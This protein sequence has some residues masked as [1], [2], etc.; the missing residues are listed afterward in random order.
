MSTTS[1]ATIV[2]ATVPARGG[3]FTFSRAAATKAEGG[4]FVVELSDD[5]GHILHI[6]FHGADLK[7]LVSWRLLIGL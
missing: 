1:M 4:R 3:E 5:A 6:D 7:R 2:T